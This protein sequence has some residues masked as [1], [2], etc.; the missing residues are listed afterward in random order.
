MKK[1]MIVLA[2]LVALFG[3][4][5]SGL[6]AGEHGGQEHGG[7]AVEGAHM[8]GSHGM[9]EDHAATLMEAAKVLKQSHP[10]LAKKLEHM[11]EEMK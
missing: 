4:N 1:L 10:E 7:T 9:A 8:E 5:H 6:L 2:M 3:V 11:A